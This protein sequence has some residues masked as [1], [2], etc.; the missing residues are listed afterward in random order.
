MR[1]QLFHCMEA[2]VLCNGLCGNHEADHVVFQSLARDKAIDKTIEHAHRM[3]M[4]RSIAMCQSCLCKF[5]LNRSR[6]IKSFRMSHTKWHWGTNNKLI[7][8]IQWELKK[9]KNFAYKNYLMMISS[10]HNKFS[11][12]NILNWGNLVLWFFIVISKAN[13]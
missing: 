4:F 10:G 7:I 1:E 8:L 6:S 2:A 12:F 11:F 13:C 9:L 5:N 3:G